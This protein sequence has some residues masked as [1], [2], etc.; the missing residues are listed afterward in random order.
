[1]TMPEKVLFAWSSGKDS[2][3]ALHEIMRDNRFAVIGL[4]TTVTADY[5]RI[6]M[7]GVRR[8]LLNEQAASIGLP[9]ETVLIS[10]EAT[11]A[12]YERAMR[13]ALL[14]CRKAGVGTIA[15]GD[16]FLEDLRKYREE[17]LAE[18]GMRAVFPLWKRD[19]AELARSFL[20]SGFRAV[21]TCADTRSLPCSAAGAEYDERFLAG[22]PEGVD[23]CG[24]N[25][26]FHSFCYAGPVFRKPLKVIRG[27]RVLR[28]ERF[29]FM[30]LIPQSG[31]LHPPLSRRD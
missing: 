17:K 28:E 24:E 21:V 13:Q 30:D 2:A 26:E 29:C 25:G 22:I 31:A 4:L 12:S 10:K 1:M 20:G 9:L 3:M 8:E 6:S 5:E 23:P 7:H 15:F 16:I 19:T 27:E 11:N 18:A 14:R